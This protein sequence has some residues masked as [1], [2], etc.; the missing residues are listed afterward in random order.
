MM[1]FCC[2]RAI[3][4]CTQVAMTKSAPTKGIRVGLPMRPPSLDTMRARRAAGAAH[5][6]PEFDVYEADFLQV[7]NWILHE[8]IFC[9]ADQ[10]VQPAD[11]SASCEN[12]SKLWRSEGGR[13]GPPLCRRTWRAC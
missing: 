13:R 7:A 12:A 3:G 1:L 11:V 10:G 8:P 4:G 6:Y 9:P 5:A 2:A